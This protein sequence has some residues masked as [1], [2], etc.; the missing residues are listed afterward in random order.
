MSE[1]LCGRLSF[2]DR[3]AR[4]LAEPLLDLLDAEARGVHET[5][6]AHRPSFDGRP[7]SAWLVTECYLEVRLWATCH[8][9]PDH[10]SVNMG[11]DIFFWHERGH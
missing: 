7:P 3:H 5:A 9:P 1:L 10:T 8:G 4:Q 6:Q 11:T 2:S